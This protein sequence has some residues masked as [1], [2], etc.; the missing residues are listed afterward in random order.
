MEAMTV[1]GEAAQ[2]TDA[3]GELLEAGLDGLIFS[4][5]FVFEPDE[6]ER[7]GALLAPLLSR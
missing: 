7:A 5:P 3:I 2:V 4:L 6:I 1:R